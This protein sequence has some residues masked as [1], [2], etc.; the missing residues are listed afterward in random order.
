MSLIL[1]NLV[2]LILYTYFGYFALVLILGKILRKKVLKAN[3]EPHVT[4]LI[5]AYNEEKGIGKKIEDSLHLDYPRDK[6]RIIVV[7]DA[8]SDQTDN[9]V[10][11]YAHEGVELFRVEGRVGKTEARNI[12]LASIEGEIIIFSDATTKYKNDIIRKLVR[13]F[14]DP[15]VGMATGHLVYQDESQ[16]H[17]GTG[18]ILYWKYE[19]LIKKAQTAMGTLTGSVGC[20]TAFRKELYTALPKNIIEDFTEPLMF[21]IKGYRVVY[22]EE[23]LC[24]EETTKKTGNEWNMRIRVIRGGMTG[25]LHAR[26]ILNPFVYPVP[27]FQL[28]SHKILRWLIPVFILGIFFLNNLIVFLEPDSLYPKVLLYLQF[29]FYVTAFF[30]FLLEKMGIRFRLAAIP[31]YFIVLNAASL[32]ALVKTITTDLEA[33]W[34][35]HREG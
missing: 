26:K 16:S 6:L 13:N 28:M 24:F 25:M 33:T 31:L 23:A 34:E 11:S 10:K 2:L 27:F 19:S 22:E 9:I 12:A 35:T 32:V 30:S 15:S 20:V 17:M 21:V 5:A 29:L 7:S 1:I 14:A 3:I 18:Q 4:M 8:S